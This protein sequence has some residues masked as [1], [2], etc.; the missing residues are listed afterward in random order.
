M[1][2]CGRR[3]GLAA[4]HAVA[5]GLATPTAAQAADGNVSESPQNV[6]GVGGAVAI[7]FPNVG[8]PVFGFGPGLGYERVLSPLVSIAISSAVGFVAD[9]DAISVSGGISVPIYFAANAPTGLYLAPGAAV[10]GVVGSRY[11][12]F[13]GGVSIGYQHVYQSGFVIG[14]SAGPSLTIVNKLGSD[15][16]FGFGCGVLVG[17]AF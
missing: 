14:G 10:G 12:A 6:I 3:S 2:T 7:V 16:T 1:T 4:L 8:D 11:L 13:G 5:I 17:Y 9:D 15:L